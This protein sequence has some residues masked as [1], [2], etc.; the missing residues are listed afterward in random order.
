MKRGGYRPGGGRPR[1]DAI[2]HDIVQDANVEKMQP[3]EYMIAVM[4]DRTADAN[5][6]D[7]MAIAAAPYCHARLVD[8]RAIRKRAQQKAIET[9]G[10]GTAWKQDLEFEIRAN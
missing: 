10:L 8:D 1:K 9:A 3:L 5:R 4:N 6:R 7:R 2:P